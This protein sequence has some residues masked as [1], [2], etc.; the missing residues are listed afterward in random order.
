MSRSF[1]ALLMAGLFLAPVSAFAAQP[2]VQ[3]HLSG[4]LLLKEVGGHVKEVP[5]DKAVAKKGDLI[6]YTIVASNIGTKPALALTPVGHVPVRTA[7]VAGSAQRVAGATVEY[8][9]DGESWS[10]RPM[11]VI[12]TAKGTEKRAADPAL[13]KSVRWVFSRALLPHK[14]DSVTYEVRV[15]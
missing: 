15:Q 4:V 1:V 13:F 11:V 8:T 6:R 5:M 14:S 3:L 12:K 7:F 2:K 9:L 10:A